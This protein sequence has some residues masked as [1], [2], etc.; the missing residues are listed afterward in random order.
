MLPIVVSLQRL[1]SNA[2]SAASNGEVDPLADVDEG[3]EDVEG[4]EAEEK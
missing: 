3:K 1:V 4:E 2:L